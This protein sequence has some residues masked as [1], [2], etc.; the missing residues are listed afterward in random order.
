MSRAP[1]IPPEQR[2]S[3]KEQAHIQGAHSSRHD[4][5]TGLEARDHGETNLREQGQQ[6]NL[7]QNLTHKGRQ[8]DR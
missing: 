1:P 6:G 4:L 2:S 7:R 8:G 3:P 5:K